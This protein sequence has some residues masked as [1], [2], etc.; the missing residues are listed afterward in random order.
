MIKVSRIKDSIIS[1]NSGVKGRKKE[2]L[3]TEYFPN[4]NTQ[5]FRNPFATQ[6]FRNPFATLSQHNPFATLLQPFRNTTLLQPFRNPFATQPFRNPFA[7]LPRIKCERYIFLKKR[8]LKFVYYID[9]VSVYSFICIMWLYNTMMCGARVK[10]R[11]EKIRY[12][13]II[14]IIKSC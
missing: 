10:K 14:V 9:Y 6:P 11:T 3:D 2:L 1:W 7:T 12:Y 4:C 8:A 13:K 5:P